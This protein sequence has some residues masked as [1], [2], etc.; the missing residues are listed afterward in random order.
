MNH[1]AKFL[2]ANVC[3]CSELDV[4]TDELN[5]QFEI[6]FSHYVVYPITCDIWSEIQIIAVSK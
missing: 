1:A 2:F 4:R 3:S 5:I 6:T